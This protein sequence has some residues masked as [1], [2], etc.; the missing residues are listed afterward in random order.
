MRVWPAACFLLAGV[1]LAGC[2][3][4]VDPDPPAPLP[5]LE[6]ELPTR[7]LWRT[8]IGVGTDG[9]RV[10]LVP[11]FDGEKLYLSD[12]EGRVAAVRITDGRRL[13]QRE[14]GLAVTGGVG[15]RDGQLYV[16]TLEGEVV[17][18]GAENG[19]TLWRS[20]VSSEILSPPQG[21]ERGVVV[22]QTVDDKVF[23]LDSRNGEQRW[24]YQQ[25]APALTLRGT[26][27][28]RVEGEVVYV[29]FSNGRLVAL[30]LADGRLIWEST[31]AV[32]KGRTELD[33]LV[34]IDASLLRQNG[35]LYVTSYQGRLA[36]VNG[37][38]GVLLWARE[39]SSY[40]AVDKSGERLFVSDARGH[41]WAVD[42]NNGASIWKQE[43]LQARGVTAPV[44]YGEYV[45]VGDYQGYLHFLSRSDGRL[46]GRVRVDDEGLLQPPLLIGN[47]LYAYGQGGVLMALRVEEER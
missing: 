13:W 20:R 46:L 35:T 25:R 6:S 17:A 36:A 23:A 18:L 16:G 22:V 32:P 31:V 3:K 10:M 44:S 15:Y 39:L 34:D 26:S 14:T 42:S 38:T 5:A 30:S 21:S 2:S 37:E 11:A 28:P 8:R 1:V 33:R 24:F 19:E 41:L 9:Q 7:T 12:R 45:V 47:L 29:G 43:K 27:T 40:Q 4:E